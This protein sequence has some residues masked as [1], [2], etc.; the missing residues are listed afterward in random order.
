MPLP[1]WLARLNKHTFNK[2]ELRRGKRPVLIH[3]GRTSGRRYETPLDAFPV[4]GGF[5][6]LVNYGPRSDWVRN[7]TAAGTA[8]LRRD[9]TIHQ[10]E[11]PRLVTNDDIW[12]ELPAA[13]KRAAAALKIGTFLRVDVAG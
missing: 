11:N 1:R 5:L 9:G 3:T 12:D 4:D 10:L 8:S 13:P 2:L 6:F 7:V